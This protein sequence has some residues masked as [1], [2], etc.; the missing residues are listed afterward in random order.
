M[1][2]ST[3]IRRGSPLTSAGGGLLSS[4]GISLREPFKFGPGAQGTVIRFQRCGQL[5]PRRHG[6][7]GFVPN[8]P[9]MFLFERINSV[10]D[11]NFFHGTYC[12]E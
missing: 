1:T 4:A 9:P 7:T 8:G 11:H 12:S 6:V 5:A 3:G 10:H 2:D